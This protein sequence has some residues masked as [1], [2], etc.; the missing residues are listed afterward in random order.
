MSDHGPDPLEPSVIRQRALS[1]WDNEGGAEP[2]GPQVGPALA[3]SQVPMPENNAAELG[4]LHV[5][6]IAL[7]NLVIS[8][9]A[10]AS[11]E[12]REQAREMARYITPRPG[13]THHPLTTHAAAH[14]VDLVER[15]ARFR[16][17]TSS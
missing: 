7:E 5:R 6:I 8:L 10:A 15:A 1:R 17:Q 13:F 16:S 9:L 4:A 3:E 14:M 11:G 12:Q 2:S